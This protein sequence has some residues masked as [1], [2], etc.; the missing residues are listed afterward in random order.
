MEKYHCN[1]IVYPPTNC[2]E[3]WTKV[4]RETEA[5]EFIP[6]VNLSNSTFYRSVP[7][8]SQKL[9]DA[10]R[11]SRGLTLT[12]ATNKEEEHA[13]P[14]SSTV[15]VAMHAHGNVHAPTRDTGLLIPNSGMNG[16]TANSGSPRDLAG[17]SV[18]STVAR[19]RFRCSSN[20]R[21]GRG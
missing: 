3:L 14:S 11:F 10:V 16:D 8:I 2:T 18:V 6:E 19:A 21:C 17:V 12:L 20:R 1:N 7:V 4:G 9:S 5:T 13:R 15:A